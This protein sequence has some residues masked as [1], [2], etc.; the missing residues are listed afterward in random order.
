MANIGNCFTGFFGV[1]WK[2]MPLEMNIPTLASS[3][4]NICGYIAAG[5]RKSL[6]FNVYLPKWLEVKRKYDRK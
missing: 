4:T 5:K 6:N 2:R 3:G 1:I